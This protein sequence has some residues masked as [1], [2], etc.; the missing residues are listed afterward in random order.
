[1]TYI[2]SALLNIRSSTSVSDSP[3]VG[4]LTTQPRAQWA[5]HYEL[6][7]KE[8]PG[9]IG[10]YSRMLAQLVSH[11]SPCKRVSLMSV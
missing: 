6:L 8:N 7:R 1:M 2:A 5:V 3:H 9:H 11:A 4:V 10:E